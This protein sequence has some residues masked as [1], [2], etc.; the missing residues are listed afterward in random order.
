MGP[1]MAARS[2][3]PLAASL[4]RFKVDVGWERRDA[5]LAL[6]P[7]GGLRSTCKP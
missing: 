3:A 5:D 4:Q 1:A 7:P 2:Y 6:H